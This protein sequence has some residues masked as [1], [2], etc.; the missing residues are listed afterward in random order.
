[1]N[2]EALLELSKQEILDLLLAMIQ[3]QGDIIKQ[4]A[5]KIWLFTL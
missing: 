3:Q 1:M 2:R 4:Q 5:E